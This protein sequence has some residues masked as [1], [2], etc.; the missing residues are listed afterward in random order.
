MYKCHNQ[1]CIPYW[2]KC[3]GADDCGDGSDEL[4]CPQGSVVTTPA[5]TTTAAAAPP[6]CGNNQYLCVSGG[7]CIFSSW[8]C[9]GMP[10]CNGGEDEQN[11]GEISHNCTTANGHYR[12]MMD[13]SCVPL[14]VVCNQHFD[15]P[16]GT[17]EIGCD[18]N[19]PNAPATPSCS[20]G[21]F[22]C[23]GNLCRPLALLCDGKVD[24]KDGYDESN[25]TNASRVYQVGCNIF[26]FLN[27]FSG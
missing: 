9:D 26:L 4:G 5:T 27:L 15:C 2:W 20:V 13:G 22:P 3:D 16:D 1:K 11:C 23:D 25:C 7:G 21:Y 18:H 8:V 14:S 6:S 24:C 10:D 19:L 12:C 17:D